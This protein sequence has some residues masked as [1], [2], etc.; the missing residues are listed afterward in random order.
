MDMKYKEPWILCDQGYNEEEVYEGMD[1]IREGDILDNNGKIIVH[2]G[3]F[4]P[5]EVLERIVLCINYCADLSNKQLEGINKEYSTSHRASEIP[6]HMNSIRKEIQKEKAMDDRS[7]KIVFQGSIE[8]FESL[9]KAVNEAGGIG[10]SPDRIEEMSASELLSILATNN[11]R[12]VYT[13][14]EKHGEPY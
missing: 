6:F 7:R 8:I 3:C 1:R 12:F 9:N 13:N 11:V 4:I 14:K 5:Y 2:D 10:F